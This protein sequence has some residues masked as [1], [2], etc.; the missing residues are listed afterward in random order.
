MSS[1]Q[2]KAGIFLYQENTVPEATGGLE[3][4]KCI[5]GQF[6]ITA[7]PYPTAHTTPLS[8]GRQLYAHGGLGLH[9]QK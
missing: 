7:M 4:R 3:L 9:K 6:F 1:K 5:L 8:V 2:V